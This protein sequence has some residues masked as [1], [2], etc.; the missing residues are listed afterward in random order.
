M[1]SGALQ[2]AL[3]VGVHRQSRQCGALHRESPDALGRRVV[4]PRSL[5]S[6][7][8]FLPPVAVLARGNSLTGFPSDDFHI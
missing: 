8:S 5:A 6:G 1:K 3:Q 2:V 7:S 4:G